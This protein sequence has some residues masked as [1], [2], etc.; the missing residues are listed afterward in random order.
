MD[1]NDFDSFQ[2]IFESLPDECD[3]RVKS[4]VGRVV[5][6]A[7]PGRGRIVRKRV[8]AAVQAAAL[9]AAAFFAAHY[10][11]RPAEFS[12]ERV[13]ASLGETQQVTL[14]DSSVIWLRSGGDLFYPES[15]SGGQR[16]VFLS[17]ELYA[18]ITKDPIHPFVIDMGGSTLEVY[19]TSFGLKAYPDTDMIEVSLVTGSVKTIVHAGDGKT[20]ENDIRPGERLRVSRRSGSYSLTSFNP[21]YYIPFKDKRVFTFDNLPLSEIIER[22]EEGFGVDII[23]LSKA[24]LSERF[25]AYFNGG[26]TLDDILGHVSPGLTYRVEE[27]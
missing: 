2:Q 15:F 20:Y 11:L 5:F 27:R 8:F 14:P 3:A 16:K 7:L 6:A 12:V 18:E 17:G 4:Q 24:D 1:K 19:G 10:M 9:L 21:D 23:L 13:H 26:E 25:F 22:L